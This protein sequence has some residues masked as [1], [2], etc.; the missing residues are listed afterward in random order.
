MGCEF[1][2]H[3]LKG[4]LTEEKVAEWFKRIHAD[5]C[6]ESGNGGYSG[7]WAEATGISFPPHPPFSDENVSGAW[8]SENAPKF[9]NAY[10][11]RTYYKGKECWHVGANCSD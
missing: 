7:T 9:G 11:V 4:T 6:Y 3:L 5:A 2:E 10:A 1:N 8:L